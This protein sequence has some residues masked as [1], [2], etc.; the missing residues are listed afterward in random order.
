MKN[1]FYIISTGIVVGFFVFVGMVQ[2]AYSAGPETQGTVVSGTLT[3]NIVWS[4]KGSPYILTDTVTI[5]KGTLTIEPGVVIR[6]HPDVQSVRVIVSNGNAILHGTAE[7]HITIEGIY[8]FSVARGSADISYVDTRTGGPGLL[9]YWSTVSVASSTFSQSTG[10]GVYI[11]GGKVDIRSSRLEHN[12]GGG[13][14]VAKDAIGESKASVSVRESAIVDNGN[15]AI[16]NSNPTS[17]MAEQNWWGSPDGPSLSGSGA[18]IGVVSYKNWLVADPAIVSPT[19]CSSVLFIPGL[20][21]S[22]MYR[23][24]RDA[25]GVMHTNQLW[26]PNRNDDV[27]KLFL[28]TTG[29]ST[30]TTIYAG[31]PIDSALGVAEV[32][33]SFMEYL[34]GL[35]KSDKIGEWK[36]YGYDWRKP[37][38][39]VVAGNQRR[40]TTTDKSLVEII[41]DLAS[42]SETGKVSIVAHSN[43]GLVAKYLVKRLEDM[44]KTNLVDQVISAGVPYLGTPQA[45]LGLLH[46]DNQSIG[47][48]MI[49]KQSI[50]RELG[51]NMS[52]AYSLLPSKEYFSKILGP[53]I[54]FASTTIAGIN[55][56]AYQKSIDTYSGQKDFI[57]DVKNSRDTTTS[58]KV[59]FPIE[60][61]KFLFNAAEA[62][63][64]I[65]DPFSWPSTIAHWALVGW[66]NKTAKGIIYSEKTEC[67]GPGKRPACDTSAVYEPTNT[68]LGDGTV[69]ASSAAHDAD[70]LISV[71][72]P[73]QSD[74]D[75]TTIKHANILESSTI[76][77]AIGD[78]IT[79]QTSSDDRK[80]QIQ[81][82]LAKLP[83]VSVG[84]IGNLD[85]KEFLMIST[86]SPVDLHL[87][88]E[89]GNHTGLTAPPVGMEFE[90]DDELDA[91]LY[92]FYEEKVPGTSFELH[93]GEDGNETYI[94][95][96]SDFS[97]T[98]DVAIRGTGI[99]TFDYIVERI[100]GDEI[101][102]RAEYLDIPVSPL[103]MATGTVT[104]S[105][106]GQTQVLA[107]STIL[108]VDI[109]RNG[110]PDLFPLSKWSRGM[111]CRHQ[112]PFRCPIRKLLR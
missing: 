29:S 88:D 23:D 6:S 42:R 111:S 26:E 80:E 46:G 30:D 8:A 76:Q 16:R 104:T 106:E 49:L 44:G 70:T 96:P 100:R 7:E 71:D 83:G 92:S 69:I 94:T 98:Y 63:H 72:L 102:D 81:G 60:G 20:Q 95:M 108:R 66:G 50:A 59:T 9:L 48:G 61:N 2:I 105:I 34:D 27:R 13:I 14:F 64:A 67:R 43:G 10:A 4:K 35:K 18:L 75:G 54:A 97:G 103:T 21:A 107:S 38:V 79:T 39:E 99:G 65:L 56:G 1:I 32:Y 41:E 33:G 112:G 109:D 22:R 12:L 36:S 17:V 58:S 31:N 40:A 57:L 37:I 28:D 45:M 11:W 55:E 73:V 3:G 53:S 15:F 93:E 62:L 19:C 86:H 5:E 110:S 90:D 89:R 91:D 78:I 47:G 25:F 85:E 82:E 84:E 87:Y 68:S 52:S 74:I 101:I 77:K 24:E 51:I